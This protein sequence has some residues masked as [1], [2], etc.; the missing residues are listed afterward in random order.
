[1]RTTVDLLC[2][3]K[4]E[5][6]IVQQIRFG[7]QTHVVMPEGST[8]HAEAHSLLMAA[9]ALGM[10][11]SRGRVLPGG[12]RRARLATGCPVRCCS[13]SSDRFK[14]SASSSSSSSC[15][16]HRA[17]SVMS[18]AWQ[19]SAGCRIMAAHSATLICF[20]QQ[21][22][23]SIKQGLVYCFQL[24]RTLHGISSTEADIG[25]VLQS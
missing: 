9:S 24:A 18:A 15:R 21:L 13:C 2:S 19:G 3:G 23:D 22:V 6:Q 16:H 7:Q 20:T 4:Q 1:M 5:P 11:S 25:G 12:R 14:A 10:Y 8:M 17:G